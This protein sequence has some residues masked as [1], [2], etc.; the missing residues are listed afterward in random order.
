MI[1]RSLEQSDQLDLLERLGRAVHAHIVVAPVDGDGR[2]EQHAAG[3]RAAAAALAAA[4]STDFEVGADADGRPRWPAGY[5]GSI[6]HTTTWAVAA[7]APEIRMTALGI[8]I[9]VSG[10]LPADDAEVVLTAAE[11]AAVCAAASP[12]RAATLRWSAKEAA[13][14]VWS[15]IHRSAIDPVDPL[16]IDVAIVD[17]HL[18]VVARGALRAMVGAHVLTG[19]WVELDGQFVTVIAT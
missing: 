8:D 12:A 11:R 2:A 9:E 19:R 17:D 15:A 14:K 7:A 4:G 13:F 16:D 18:T 1:A 10:A 6:A 3:R 5:V